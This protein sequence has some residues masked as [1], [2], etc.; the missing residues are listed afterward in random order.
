MVFSIESF[1]DIDEAIGNINLFKQVTASRLARGIA[2]HLVIGDG[3]SKPLGLIPSLEAVGVPSVTASGSAVNTGGSETGANSLGSED[4]SA[5]LAL[6]DEGYVA[7]A[8]CAWFMNKKTLAN[9]SGIVTKYGRLLNL[10]QYENGKPSIFGIPVK[11][12]PSMDNI[13]ASAVPVVL[14]DG[15]YW[16]TRLVADENSGIRVYSE[17]TG[18]VEFG[19]VGMSCFMRADGELL[20]SDTNSPAPF[21][22]IRNHS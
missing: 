2:K 8:K 7:S 5:A 18:L 9:I 20:Y 6:L 3:S 1:Q 14:G 13:G 12:C 19:N 10:I 15:T 21:T 22:F 4:F 11:I 17:A 16:A